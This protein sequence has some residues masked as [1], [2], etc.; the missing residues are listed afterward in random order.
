MRSCVSSDVMIA[1][2]KGL[3]A[4]E[5]VWSARMDSMYTCAQEL[6]SSEV[7]RKHRQLVCM[8]VHAHARACVCVRVRMCMCRLMS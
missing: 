7:A 4:P 5:L 3:D 6:L 8:S 2:C 1:S